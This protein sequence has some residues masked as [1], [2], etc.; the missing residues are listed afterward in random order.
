MDYS[1]E[2]CIQKEIIK[3]SEIR[4]KKLKLQ[5]EIE[6]DEFY[7]IKQLFETYEYNKPDHYDTGPRNTIILD[8]PELRDWM[9]GSDITTRFHEIGYTVAAVAHQ[10][11]DHR[12][13]VWIEK[14]V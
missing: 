8:Y 1:D 4:I 14:I 6:N 12:Y 10:E 5:R 11:E 2:I 13:R 3:T 7:E 9:M